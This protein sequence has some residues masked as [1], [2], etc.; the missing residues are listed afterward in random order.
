VR[1]DKEERERLL[2]SWSEGRDVRLAALRQQV[3]ALLDE[4]CRSAAEKTTPER[5]SAAGAALGAAWRDSGLHAADLVS[6]LTRVRQTIWDAVLARLAA[7]SV[8]V[9]VAARRSLDVVFDA[10]LPA[11]VAAC[12]S[13]PSSVVAADPQPLR[14]DFDAT[15]ERMLDESANQPLALVF[16]HVDLA[17]AATMQGGADSLDLSQV[18]D[19][20]RRRDD[21]AF[22]L[23]DY[24]FAIIC[25]RTDDA[26]G[27]R[28]IE[29]LDAA[30]TQ[31]ARGSNLPLEVTGGLA[32][33]PA[34]GT[35]STELI[36][37]ALADREFTLY[38]GPE[39]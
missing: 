4:G 33:S 8:D 16:V 21:A 30:M 1:I 13:A 37:V 35:T 28:L 24:D 23:S 31:Y 5:G 29:R 25:P 39:A 36:R 20:Q 19:S 32:V 3:A 2:A 10:A 12:V 27:R 26:G 17:W 14:L 34:D 9:V 18:L 22:R 6:E 15:L 38:G 11:A 7:A